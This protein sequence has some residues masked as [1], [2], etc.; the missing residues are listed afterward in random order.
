MKL[1]ASEAAAPTRIDLAGGTLDIWPISQLIEDSVTVNLAV[2]LTAHATVTPRRDRRLEV[3]SVDR[4]RQIVH[5]LPLARSAFR[6][7]LS[8]LV[9]LTDAFAPGVP[10]TLTCRAEAP[11]AGY[12]PTSH[13]G[14]SGSTSWMPM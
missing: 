13:S 4:G 12:C 3:V 11:A 6:G 10:L 14:W 5:E 8:W 2:T 9:R 7:P 1:R